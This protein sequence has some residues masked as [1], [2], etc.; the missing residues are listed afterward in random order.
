[1]PN[2]RRIRHVDV[3]MCGQVGEKGLFRARPG[4]KRAVDPGHATSASSS[5]Y[6]RTKGN[7]TKQEGVFYLLKG[8]CHEI[9]SSFFFS[10]TAL[11][12]VLI[13]HQKYYQILFQIR[14]VI[15]I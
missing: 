3:R 8:Q 15:R 1:M 6:P 5:S 11:S 7:H 12:G 14:R 13:N 2:K 10:R 9:F 4:S